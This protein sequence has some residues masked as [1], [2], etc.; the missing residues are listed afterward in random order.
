MMGTRRK[1]RELVLQMLFQSDMGKQSADQV[2]KTF[3][4]QRSDVEDDARGFA[5]DLFRVANE[6]LRRSMPPSRSTP[7]IG[8]SSEWPQSIA[9]CFEPAWPNS[10]D[11]R[12]LPSRSSS[13]K[14]WRSRASFLRPSRFT[15]SMACSTPSP[16]NWPSRNKAQF[17]TQQKALACAR[18]F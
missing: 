2:T 7:I 1:S 16:K 8:D 12:R 3:W 14:P 10:W 9:T 15:S 17:S 18:D 4:A 5:E 6:R 11:T 13:T